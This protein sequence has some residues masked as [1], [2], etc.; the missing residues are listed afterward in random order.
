MQ[1]GKLHWR[2]TLP[3]NGLKLVDCMRQTKYTVDRCGCGR[4]GY[5]ALLAA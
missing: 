3:V 1:C 4:V 2:L 5:T